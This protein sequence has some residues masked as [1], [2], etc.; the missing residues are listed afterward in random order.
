VPVLAVTAYCAS[1][2]CSVIVLGLTTELRPFPSIYAM[3]VHEFKEHA[4][5]SL[6]PL[7]RL[8]MPAIAIVLSIAALAGCDKG[9]ANSSASGGPGNSTGTATG[10]TSGGST[11]A[12]VG[13]DNGSGKLGGTG[14][15]GAGGTSG[16]GSGSAR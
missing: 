6:S 5:L 3:F 7:S 12:T 15:A 13:A 2:P 4:M 16:S 8:S 10:S 14:S 9:D 1:R 11:S